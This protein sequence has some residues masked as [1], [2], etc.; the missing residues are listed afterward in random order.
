MMEEREDKGDER[1]IGHGVIVIHLQNA[2]PKD[3]ASR[4]HFPVRCVISK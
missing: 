4:V 3:S 1:C 2:T